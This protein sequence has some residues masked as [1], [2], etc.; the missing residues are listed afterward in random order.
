MHKLLTYKDITLYCSINKG[1]DG[2]EYTDTRYTTQTW[3]QYQSCE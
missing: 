2:L 3:A 1:I